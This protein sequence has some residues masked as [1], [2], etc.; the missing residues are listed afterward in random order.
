MSFVS[1]TI[2]NNFLWN[3]YW[4]FAQIFFSIDFFQNVNI[5]RKLSLG[6][7]VHFENESLRNSFCW[8]VEIRKF[9]ESILSNGWMLIGNNHLE[10]KVFLKQNFVSSV[11]CIVSWCIFSF[12]IIHSAV[13]PFKCQFCVFGGQF[14][15]F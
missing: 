9:L 11:K 3:V 6:S 15:F 13:M 4:N 2:R 5:H 8:T 10:I 14:R 1:N 7:N 12:P